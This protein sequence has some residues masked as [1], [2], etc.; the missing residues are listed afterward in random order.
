MDAESWRFYLDEDVPPSAAQIGRDLGLDVVAVAEAGLRG[1]E[2]VEQLEWA[3]A[4]S[5]VIVTYNRNDFLE[6]T[7]SRAATGKPHAGVLIVVAGVP[8]RAAAIAHAL[9]RFSAARPPLQAYEV[10]FLS[11]WSA[12]D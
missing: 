12:G 10:Q 6:L 3:A 8:R 9:Q 1:R 4:R 11:A 5:R 2:D 7:R